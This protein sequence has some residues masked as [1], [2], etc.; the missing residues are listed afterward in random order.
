MSGG[1]YRLTQLGR[2]VALAEARRVND[3]LA[4]A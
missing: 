1:D 4:Q 3:M 2:Q